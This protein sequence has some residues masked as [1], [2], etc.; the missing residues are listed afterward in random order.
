MWAAAGAV[1]GIAIFLAL[2]AGARALPVKNKLPAYRGAAIASILIA[3]T[4]A[5]A[6]SLKW[7]KDPPHADDGDS[8]PEADFHQIFGRDPPKGVTIVTSNSMDDTD[9]AHANVVLKIS[10]RTLMDLVADWNPGAIAKGAL[11]ES[12]D[13]STPG[14]DDERAYL[15]RPATRAEEEYSAVLFCADDSTAIAAYAKIY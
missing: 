10:R 14:C 3:C 15:D 8:N 5:A 6:P 1:L 13:W 7:P 2:T 9:G 11:P 4:I 12:E